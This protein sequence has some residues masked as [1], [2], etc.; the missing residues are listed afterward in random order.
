MWAEGQVI[1]L[2]LGEARAGRGPAAAAA[3]QAGD[4]GSGLLAEIDEIA[5]QKQ[6][7]L[8]RSS[9]PFCANYRWL[10]KVG[11]RVS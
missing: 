10:L 1:T 3:R 11:V 2:L 6:R 5:R 9:G 8:R 4:K 7:N